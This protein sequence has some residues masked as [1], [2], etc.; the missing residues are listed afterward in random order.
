MMRAG[1]ERGDDHDGHDFHAHFVEVSHQLGAVEAQGDDARQD[2]A[3]QHAHAAG[4]VLGDLEETFARP[5]CAPPEG[6]PRMEGARGAALF[7]P[8]RR[9]HPR[10]A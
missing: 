3:E 2:L 8:G 7:S 5:V 4:T 10:R 6:M 1:E 9:R